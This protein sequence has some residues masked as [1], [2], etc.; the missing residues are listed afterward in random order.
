MD[1][2]NRRPPARLQIRRHEHLHDA[3]GTAAKTLVGAQEA[4][5]EQVRERDVLRV[6]GLGQPSRSAISQEVGPRAAGRSQRIGAV[7]M[8]S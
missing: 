5:V 1:S 6:V 3:A 8:L 2:P 7:A 4:A